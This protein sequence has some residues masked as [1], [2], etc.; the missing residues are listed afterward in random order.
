MSL[1]GAPQSGRRGNLVFKIIPG[2]ASFLHLD[3]DCFARFDF[4]EKPASA[5]REGLAT[6]APGAHRPG[7]S[8]PG[9]AGVTSKS[10]L[11]YPE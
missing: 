2:I 4:G 3:G 11:A 5:Q 9:S 7:W 8:V 1:R 10:Q 6:L